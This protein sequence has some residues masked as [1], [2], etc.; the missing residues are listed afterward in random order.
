MPIATLRP[1]SDVTI[2][3]I[4]F[5]AGVGNYGRVNET[6]A[7]D[8]NGVFRSDSASTFSDIYGLPDPSLS[9]TISSV[10]VYAR[11][12]RT[13]HAYESVQGIAQL[14]V[15]IGGTSYLSS[16]KSLAA[17]AGTVSQAWATN[18][19]TSA[20]WTWANINDL[21]VVVSLSPGLWNDGKNSGTLT[22]YA[23]QVWVE[24]D[25]GSSLSMPLLLSGMRGGYFGMRGGYV[26]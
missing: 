13:G 18:P 10:T 5:G 19:N 20:A 4:T 22:T 11:A 24:V 26:N 9:G 2:A 21:R 15:F 17:T 23:S 6:T 8:T 12:W 7:D 3:L 1:D 25:Y 16:S 14:G